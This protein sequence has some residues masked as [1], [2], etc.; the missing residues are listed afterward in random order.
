MTDFINNPE[1]I[2][3]VLDDRIILIVMVIFLLRFKYATYNNIW[4]A[5]LV[6]IPGTIFHELAHFLMPDRLKFLFSLKKILME[7]I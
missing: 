6:N 4:L 3:A 5:A 1:F 7:A 2:K